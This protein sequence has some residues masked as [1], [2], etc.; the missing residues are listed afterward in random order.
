MADTAK[1]LYGPAQLGTSATT[2]Y[3][4]PASTRTTVLRIRVVNTGTAPAKFYLSIGADAAGTRLYS[5]L[6][7]PANGAPVI[8]QAYEVLE[9]GETIQAYADTA[10]T[11]TLTLEGVQAT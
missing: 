3:T 8:E 6:L 9:A 4:S 1:R 2:I 10:S 5:G 7:I 11:L